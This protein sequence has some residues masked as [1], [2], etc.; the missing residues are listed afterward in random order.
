M[1]LGGDIIK[2]NPLDKALQLF[3]RRHRID[4]QI[5]KYPSD[6]KT[7]FD[8]F[9]RLNRG[10]AYAN[11]QE[12]RTCS[13]VLASPAFTKS[14]REICRENAFQEVFQI[15]QIQRESQKDIEYAV[16][17]I[18]HTFIDY[19]PGKD[20]QAFLD[21]SILKI[22][23]EFDIGMVLDTVKWVVNL[24]SQSLGSEALLPPVDVRDSL[25]NRFS[26]RALEGVVV[27]LARHRA[28]IETLPNPDDFAKVRIAAFWQQPEVRK[29]ATPG[30]TG[31]TRLQRTI[32]FGTRWFDPHASN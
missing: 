16:R 20:V 18:V 29:M 7:K 28:A 22:I 11:E 23:D 31:T 15:T 21:T 6:P 10:G 8:L 26:L 2:Q 30:L 17:I 19:H 12:V 27:G 32:P 4:F 24:L 3:F 9:Q 13:M 5:L 14:I 25:A 1:T